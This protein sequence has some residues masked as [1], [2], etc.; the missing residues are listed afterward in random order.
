M[1]PRNVI[2][3]AAVFVLGLVAGAWRELT[4]LRG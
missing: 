3:S 4:A 1:T 2:T